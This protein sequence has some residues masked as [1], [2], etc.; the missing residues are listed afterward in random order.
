MLPRTAAPASAVTNPF[1]AR[2]PKRARRVRL[3]LDDTEP[4]D[5]DAYVQAESESHMAADI[6]SNT[7]GHGARRTASEVVHVT[8]AA[9]TCQLAATG[10]ADAV[11][12]VS[13]AADIHRLT[14]D[15]ESDTLTSS[16]GLMATASASPASSTK[17]KINSSPSR[18]EVRIVMRWVLA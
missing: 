16:S 3:D 13:G 1:G 5:D 7:Q 12:R 6:V 11:G 10:D 8:A 17:K 15:A 9:E 14:G 18:S 2:A 4:V